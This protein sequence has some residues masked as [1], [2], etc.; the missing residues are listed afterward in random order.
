[1]IGYVTHYLSQRAAGC[2]FDSRYIDPSIYTHLMVSP[3]GFTTTG[4]LSP[5]GTDAS[6][7]WYSTM[8]NL[9]QKNRALKVMVGHVM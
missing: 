7:S 3:V 6:S 8:I 1:M 2:T 4:S 9:K 5:F